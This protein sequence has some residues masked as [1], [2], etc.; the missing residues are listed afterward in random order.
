MFLLFE[1]CLCHLPVRFLIH[2][3]IMIRLYDFK[4]GFIWLPIDEAQ[5]KEKTTPFHENVKISNHFSTSSF[6]ANTPYPFTYDGFATDN[7]KMNTR[8]ISYTIQGDDLIFEAIFSPTTDFLTF[9]QDRV[10]DR[11][12]AI[13]VSVADKNLLTNF[14]DRVSLLLDV[15]DMDLFIPISGEL[16][17]V[18]TK[19]IEHPENHLVAGVDV[20]EGF[21]EDDVLARSYFGLEIGKRLNQVVM[22]YEVENTITG[23]TFELERFTANCQNFISTPQGVQEIDFN[24]SRGYKL[25]PNNNKNWVKIIRDNGGDGNGKSSYQLLFAQKLRWEYWL[26]K[27][28]VP[29]E[30][31]DA[32]QEFNGSNNDWLHYL[33]TSNVHKVNFFILFDV[34]TNGTTTRLK[35]T[36]PITFNGYD[37]NTGMTIE[38]S[39]YDDATNT[40]LNIGTDADTGRPLGVLLSSKNTRIEIIYTKLSDE[41]D[42]NNIYAVTTIEI[43]KGAGVMTH[44]QLSSIVDSENDNILIPLNGETKLKVEQISPTVIKTSCLVDFTRLDKATRYKITGRIGCFANNNGIPIPTRIYDEQN[45]EPNYE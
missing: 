13:W 35:N 2:Y 15:N 25:A 5:Y 45:Y 42:I 17:G 16:Q 37:E 39:Y 31:F 29:T 3:S 7:A 44:R 20:Y 19:F 32:T 12:F 26:Q 21:L 1:L 10:D 14:S 23:A 34:D 38:H 4:H 41:W 36:F 43:D 18:T 30:F 28:N 11:K 9:F 27:A 22:G 40:L 8:A 33:R 6:N 24:A